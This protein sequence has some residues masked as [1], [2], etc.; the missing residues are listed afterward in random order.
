MINEVSSNEIW[1]GEYFFEMDST[2]YNI[3]VYKK[4]VYY[5]MINIGNNLPYD[6]FKQCCEEWFIDNN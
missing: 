4:M 1:I 3:H 5:D 2:N 6:V